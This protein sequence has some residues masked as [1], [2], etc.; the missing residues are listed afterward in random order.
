MYNYSPEAL[1]DSF[2]ENII[3][4]QQYCNEDNC[5]QYG[6]SAETNK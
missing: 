5:Q 2:I 4:F 1:Q 6:N 3:S